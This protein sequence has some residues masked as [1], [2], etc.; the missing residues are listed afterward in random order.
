MLQH[1]IK[2]FADNS[3]EDEDTHDVELT[4]VPKR[5]MQVCGIQAIPPFIHTHHKSIKAAG[6]RN[7]VNIV[8]AHA[9][10]RPDVRVKTAKPVRSPLN[11]SSRYNGK[12]S[13]IMLGAF[14]GPSPGPAYR[15]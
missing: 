1:L 10:S 12:L 14:A 13:D 15:C 2:S 4:P 7:N 8:K 6:N 3:D 11:L 9:T 5:N